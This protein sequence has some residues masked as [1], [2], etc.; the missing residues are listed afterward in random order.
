MSLVHGKKCAILVYRSTNV[1]ITLNPLESGR[2][3]IKSKD[4]DCHGPLR[5]GNDCSKPYEWCWGIFALQYVSHVEHNLRQ[6]YID[7]PT[8]MIVLPNPRS[9]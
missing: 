6:I 3:S 2:S 9:Y 8:R 7:E 4:I 1:K 5:V